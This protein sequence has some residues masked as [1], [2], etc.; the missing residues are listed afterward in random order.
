MLNPYALGHFI[1]HPPPD[2]AANVKTVDLDLPYTFFPSFMGRYI[3]FINSNDPNV[4]RQ[5]KTETRNQNTLRAVA[6][7]SQQTIAH[8]EELFLDYIADN[9]TEID[10]TPDWLIEPPH[11]SP[12]LQKKEMVTHLPL[13][14]RA[15]IAYDQ[16][17]K[18]RKY[19]EFE[20]RTGKE[21]TPV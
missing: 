10:Y 8:G 6:I 12:Y 9:R 20:G 17:K 3:P 7:V 1:N 15:L 19:D 4:K 16:T 11:P 18:G 2:V 5:E 14:V 21:L 13:V